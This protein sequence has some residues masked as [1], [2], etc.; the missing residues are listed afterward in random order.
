MH[1][2]S[3]DTGETWDVPAVS[4]VPVV[5]PTGCGNAFCGGFLA[6]WRAGDALLDAGLWVRRE[7]RALLLLLCRRAVRARALTSVH[8]RFVCFGTPACP[9]TT[10]RDAWRLA[11]WC[12]RVRRVHCAWLQRRCHALLFA[13]ENVC[14]TRNT[15]PCC[16]SQLECQAVP[17]Q[18]PHALRALA[19]QRLAALRLRA[20]RLA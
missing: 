12:A 14:V 3:A 9:C 5:D 16:S 18:P 1:A 11:S 19:L 6:A 10:G 2:R 17:A 8:A 13:G 15:C 20:T 7:E 4:G